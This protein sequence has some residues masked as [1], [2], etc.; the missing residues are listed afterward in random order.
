MIRF[1]DIDAS[2]IFY[3]YAISCNA[4]ALACGVFCF[5]LFGIAVKYHFSNSDEKTRYGSNIVG[6]VLICCS[7]TIVELGI[8]SFLSHIYTERH[9]VYAELND[10]LNKEVSILGSNSGVKLSELLGFIE[11]SDI[12]YFTYD[13][14]TIYIV[15]NDELYDTI[16][17]VAEY[18]DLFYEGNYSDLNVDLLMSKYF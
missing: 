10:N 8:T 4:V 17:D 6:A 1:F 2:D 7:I 9:E 5:V 15:G 12:E 18:K 3:L 11:P 16:K 14:D 13:R